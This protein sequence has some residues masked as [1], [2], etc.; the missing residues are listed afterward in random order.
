LG[1]FDRDVWMGILEY[2]EE[3]SGAGR[4]KNYPEVI[5]LGSSK[6]F[7]KRLGKPESGRYVAMFQESIKRLLKTV[8]FSERAFNCPSSGGYLNVLENMTLLTAAAFKGEP[9]GRG[10]VHQTTWVKLG[11]YVRK[12]LESGYIA[13]IDVKYV[14]QL[15]GEL[16]KHLY[17]FLSYRF[18]LAA[19]RGRDYHQ[20]HWEELRDYLA[21]SGWDNLSR[22]KDRL[23]SALT[24][25][26]RREYI[27]ETS[28]WSGPHYVFRFGKKFIDELATRFNAKEQYKTWIV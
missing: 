1:T 25:L 28:D 22:A 13:L 2:A 6:G 23:K 19:Q 5:D 7:L 9:D 3:L 11:D 16:S 27:D 18:W 20:V 4:S 17:P 8:C 12:N 21:A 24:E 10:G 26:K 14:R 15:I